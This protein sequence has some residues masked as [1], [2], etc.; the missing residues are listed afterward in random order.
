MA[1]C[2]PFPWKGHHTVKRRPC[3]IA[4]KYPRS[5]NERSRPIL[6][7]PLL[8]LQYKEIPDEH[9][10]RRLILF[11]VAPQRPMEIHSLRSLLAH[12][13]LKHGGRKWIPPFHHNLS[14]R[15]IMLIKWLHDDFNHCEKQWSF[16]QNNHYVGRKINYLN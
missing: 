10:S 15:V 8:Q 3:C 6:T 2:T 4:Y 14:E 5:P 11:L 9:M 16:I 1:S 13:N 7:T 12:L